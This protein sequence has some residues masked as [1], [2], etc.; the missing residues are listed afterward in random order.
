MPQ[1]IAV[2]KYLVEKESKAGTNA[3][4]ARVNRP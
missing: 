1:M 3:R 4:A 2:A